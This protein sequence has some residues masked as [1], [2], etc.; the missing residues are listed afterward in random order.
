[1]TVPN[2]ETG[3]T[4]TGAYRRLA[5]L[6]EYEGTRYHGFQSQANAV[7]VQDSLEDALYELTGERNRM[8][9]AGRT[10]AGVH[11]LGQVVSFDTFTP[12][13]PDVF[14][15]AINHLLP[16]DISVKDASEVAPDF[17]P[18]RWATGREYRYSILESDTPTPMLRRFVHR[19]SRRLDVD[20]MQSAAVLLEGERDLAPF[21]GPL[22]NGRTSTT[23][24]VFRC[25]VARSAGLVTLEM[26]ATGFLPQQVRRT[27]GALLDV[28]LG[29]SSVRQFEE[30]ASCGVLGAVDRVA[31][32]K[33]LTLVG[34][35]YPFPLF[36]HENG[37]ATAF[38]KLVQQLSGSKPL[39]DDQDGYR[40]ASS[41]YVPHPKHPVTTGMSG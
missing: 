37:E 30:L 35:S 38:G 2:R 7:S 28:G 6:V 29:R 18:R 1:M 32:A 39:I 10:D 17:D 22:T 15:N 4:P 20:S 8:K 27:T 25:T 23:R 41:G 34:V 36:S 12:Y 5:M 13:T 14:V 21:S 26:A 24:R 9:G 40:T 19:V 3:E 16:D 33:G 11:A 31:P